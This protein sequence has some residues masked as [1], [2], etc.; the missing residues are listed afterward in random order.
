MEM[1]KTNR[2]GPG[3][4]DVNEKPKKTI[5]LKEHAKLVLKWQACLH[6]FK[7]IDDHVIINGYAIILFTFVKFIKT[8][9]TRERFSVLF[10][11]FSGKMDK[12]LLPRN[13]L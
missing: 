10:F 11:F 4:A 2:E 5:S 6:D 3:G 12:F 8:P 1:E 13:L 9:I 7:H